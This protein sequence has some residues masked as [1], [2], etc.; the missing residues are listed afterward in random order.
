M[1]PFTNIELD[2][3]G[4]V[5]DTDPLDVDSEWTRVQNMRFNDLAAQKIG[6]EVQAALTTEQP[7][8]LQ[9]SGNHDEPY[10]YY[11]G[12]GTIRGT[13]FVTDTDLDVGNAVS[14]GTF[15]DACLFNFFPIFNNTIDPPWYFSGTGDVQSLPSFPANTQ[16]IAIRPFRSFLVAMN[17]TDTGNVQPN[18]LIW[19]NSADAGALPADWAI[20]DP[21]SQ[22]GD[23]YL[24]DSRGE[25]IDGLQL[26][27][28]FII[29]KT[30]STYIMRLVGGQSVMS[31]EKVQINSGILTKN[32]VQEIKGAHFIVSD[33][34]VV[35]FDGQNVKSIADKRVRAEIFGNI[36]TINYINSY[37]VRY[38]RQDE[39]WL[40]YPTNG[41]TW[42]NKAA[43]W[44]WKD[45][46]WTFRDLSES[47]HIQS[48]LAN[49][50]VSDKW[51]AALYTWNSATFAWKPVSN[52]PTTDTLVSATDGKLGVMDQ[53]Y[54]SFDVPM[55][56]LL[57]KASMNL[58]DDSSIKLVDSVVPKI[59]ADTGTMVYIR[60]GTQNNPDDQIVWS[61]ESE[62]IVGV[63]REAHFSEKGRYISIRLRTQDS[64]ANW[65]LSGVVIGYKE[66]GKY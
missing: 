1:T 3:Y 33:A 12:D 56:S 46:T 41:Q 43:I 29:Y 13:D 39:M 55:P 63:D 58:G 4:V 57:E 34:D 19:S 27:D 48:G 40:C 20:A 66:S 64:N 54:N 25:I 35:M 49:F 16:C 8:R 18:R 22:A 15:W 61:Q 6:G 30:H 5:R 51:D 14:L 11:M 53:G 50:A 32:C 62:Y 31:I 23:A 21:T 42:P 45:N 44:N 9:F 37:T 17:I 2:P 60:V 10:W 7:Y 38:D 52:N 26:R 36:D 65:K 47:R 59:T 28:S 24:S